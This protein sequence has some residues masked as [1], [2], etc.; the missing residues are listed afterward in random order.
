MNEDNLTQDE[1][2]PSRPLTPV[3]KQWLTV[4]GVL[5]L[6]AGS[7]FAGRYTAPAP[8][9]PSN[10]VVQIPTPMPMGTPVP[11]PESALAMIDFT[12]VSAAKKAEVLDYFN[13]HLCQCGCKMTVAECMVRDPNCPFWKDHVTQFQ[14]ALGNGRKPKLAMARRPSVMMA[15]GASNGFTMPNGAANGLVLPPSGSNGF[16]PPPSTSK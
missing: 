11:V 16:S 6:M 3:Q 8:T 10:P 2:R 13:T 1:I 9:P 14:K 15:P 7:F 12:G 5:C 4:L